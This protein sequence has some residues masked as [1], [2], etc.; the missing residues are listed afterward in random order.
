V[1]V[2]LDGRRRQLA[3]AGPVVLGMALVVAALWPL[4]WSAVSPAA[5]DQ[6]AVVFENDRDV[7]VDG[8]VYVV[9]G[10]VSAV[11]VTFTNGTTARIDAPD[12]LP[13]RYSTFPHDV[14]AIR[15]ADGVVLYRDSASIPP[16]EARTLVEMT[17]H[18]PY[19]TVIATVTNG[20]G[21]LESATKWD[22][23]EDLVSHVHVELREHGTVGR[24][25]GCAGWAEAVPRL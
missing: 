12:E 17:P 16:G 18:L 24:G 25:M 2:V 7:T 22:C 19:V 11:D 6:G 1:A 3:I 21:S 5:G 20:D 8:T 9:Q 10:P 15:P 13:H 14:E 23:D 4:G